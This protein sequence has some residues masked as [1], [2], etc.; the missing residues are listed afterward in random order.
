MRTFAL[1]AL[2]VSSTALACPDLS[3]HY[4]TCRSTNGTVDNTSDVTI[5][6]NNT[7][8]LTTYTLKETND[9]TGETDTTDIKADAKTYTTTQIDPDSGVS[10]TL[11]QTTTCEGNA[12]N[13][14][15]VES[16]EDQQVVH[17]MVKITKE[18]SQVIQE[19][20][21]E[22]MGQPVSDRV[23]CE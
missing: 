11:A 4:A 17:L 19:Y 14:M 12:L 1:A 18:G 6:Q 20:S 5:S 9:T 16:A 8:G 23:I 2:F 22:A 3:G 15:M 13:I 10:I 7:N 21:G